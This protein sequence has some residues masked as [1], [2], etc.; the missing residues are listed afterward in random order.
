M[1]FPVPFI[2]GYSHQLLTAFFFFSWGAFYSIRRLDFIMISHKL[3]L[4]PVLY[5][6][7]VIA[8]VATREQAY[9]SYIHDIGILLGGVSAVIITSSLLKMGKIRVNHFLAGSSFF[10]FALHYLIVNNMGSIVLAL[11]HVNSP[12]TSIVIYFLVPA[13]TIL[14][15]LGLYKLLRKYCPALTSLLTGGR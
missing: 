2:S 9:H 4:I 1:V 5:L 12:Y 14:I 8:D 13:L 15:C 6:V 7:V 10:I 11:V 3:P